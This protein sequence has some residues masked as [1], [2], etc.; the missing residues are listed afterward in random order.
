MVDN[1]FLVKSVKF[2]KVD[3]NSLWLSI[4]HNK[5]LN[6][7]LVDITGKF[8]YTKDGNTKEGSSTIYLNLIAAK[9]LIDQLLLAYQLAKSFQDNEIA[10]IYNIFCLIFEICFIFQNRS[11]ASY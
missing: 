9:A 11:V 8:N 6:R 7:Y 1:N 10:K 4:V 3:K 2:Y 5:Q